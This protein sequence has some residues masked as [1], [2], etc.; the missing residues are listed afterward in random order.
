MMMI[1]MVV[2]LMLLLSFH[3][4][5]VI[6]SCWPCFAVNGVGTALWLAPEIIRREKYDEKADCYSFGCVTD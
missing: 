4:F 6:F 1:M 5:V 3:M 2:L